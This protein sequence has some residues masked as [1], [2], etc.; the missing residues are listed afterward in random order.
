MDLSPSPATLYFS[1]L[2]ESQ[3]RVDTDRDSRY[4]KAINA[5]PI[6]KYATLEKPTGFELGVS[7]TDSH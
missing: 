4:A 5:F 3:F 1:V 2:A 7:T 6:M